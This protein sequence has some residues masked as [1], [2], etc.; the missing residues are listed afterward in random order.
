MSEEINPHRRRLASSPVSAAHDVLDHFIA[1]AIPNQ[2][3][4]EAGRSWRLPFSEGFTEPDREEA[5]AILGWSHSPSAACGHDAKS[6]FSRRIAS[7]R[8]HAGG[9]NE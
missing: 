8:C 6:D 4:L 2:L 3:H 9:N 1:P 7:V 5:K